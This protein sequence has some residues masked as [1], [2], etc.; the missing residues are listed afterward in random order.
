M[1]N[2]QRRDVLAKQYNQLKLLD[3]K[4][5]FINTTTIRGILFVC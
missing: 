3:E 2:S 1:K 4:F 5:P